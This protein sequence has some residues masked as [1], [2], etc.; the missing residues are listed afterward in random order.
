M[1]IR[2]KSVETKIIINKNKNVNTE[3]NSIS[4]N[5][6]SPQSVEVETLK[7]LKKNI[8]LPRVSAPNL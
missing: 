1:K 6:E 3:E 8:I 4:K 2:A 5:I 7:I